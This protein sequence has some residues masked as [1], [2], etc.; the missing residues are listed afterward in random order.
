MHDGIDGPVVQVLK[1]RRD[2]VLGRGRLGATAAERQNFLWIK[3]A[4]IAG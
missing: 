4:I 3:A 1:A 2:P